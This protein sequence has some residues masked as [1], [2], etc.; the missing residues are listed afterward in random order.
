[1]VKDAD[2][3]ASEDK[4]KREEIE[5]RHKADSL[6]YQIEKALRDAGDKVSATVKAPIEN[7]IERVKKASAA[8]PL[9]RDELKKA[10]DE[11]AQTAQKIG[12]S[13]Y[14]AQQQAGAGQAGAG[15]EAPKSG[16][17]EGDEE[18]VDADY[19]VKD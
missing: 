7:A 17:A 18:V 15:Q 13:L 8:E 16:K 4:K 3:H 2:S 12:E 1:M 10:T 14:Q 6:V 9:D 11:L 19:T 5:L